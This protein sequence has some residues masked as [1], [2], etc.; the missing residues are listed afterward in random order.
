MIG[1]IIL[2]YS[3][4]FISPYN[5][6]PESNEQIPSLGGMMGKFASKSYMKKHQKSLRKHNSHKKFKSM[7]QKKIRNF[8]HHKIDLREGKK[9]TGFAENSNMKN[10]QK[11][12]IME[13]Q[14][15]IGP[16]VGPIN[17]VFH[18]YGPELSRKKKI[19]VK[20]WKTSD[21]L[22]DFSIFEPLMLL[23]NTPPNKGNVPGLAIW[24]GE[25]EQHNSVN[26][27]V[28]NRTLA[29]APGIDGYVFEAIFYYY[30]PIKNAKV[31]DNS[32]HRVYVPYIALV[33][34]EFSEQLSENQVILKDN[35]VVP[36]Y[37]NL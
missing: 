6:H 10:E 7:S 19:V 27:R 13:E 5:E 4:S 14:K 29:P 16:S 9:L 3:Q 1:I 18:N 34:K 11:K 37:D 15:K 32:N 12:L 20:N 2:N 22:I 24:A 21:L 33:T 23:P 30:P 25:L 28:F 17:Q 26:F 31:V 36:F 8:D 35:V